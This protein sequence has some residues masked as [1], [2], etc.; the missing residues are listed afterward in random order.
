MTIFM[1]ITIL[2]TQQAIATTTD[3][4]IILDKINAHRAAQGKP[5]LQMNTVISDT[6]RIH[7]RN[8][9][10]GKVPFGHDG[11]QQ[12]I[13]TITTKIGAVSSWGENVAYHSQG[14]DKVI[15]GWLNSPG[16]RQNI[17]GNFNLTGVGVAFNKQGW[18]YVTQIFILKK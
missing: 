14:Y 2:T 12:R 8:M 5:A 13:N 18:I 11:V 3:E 7:S 4:Q 9:A 17:E 15:Q 6:A 10:D 1:M 16:H